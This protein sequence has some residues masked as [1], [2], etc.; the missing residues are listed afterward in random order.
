MSGGSYDAGL[1]SDFGGGNVH[2]WQDYI[3]AE[4]S[5]S[6][7]FYAAEII[8]LN[9]ALD[10]VAAEREAWKFQASKSDERRAEAVAMF[11]DLLAALEPFSDIDGE[12]DEDFPDETPVQLMFGRTTAYK[13]VTLGDLR[14][15]REAVAKIEDR[16]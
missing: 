9:Q 4:L 16:E 12:G 13:P 14:A 6:H 2:W 15:A 11:A 5:R 3:R 1:L 8:R 7:D 10:M